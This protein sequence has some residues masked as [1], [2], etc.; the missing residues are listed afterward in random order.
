MFVFLT[1][2]GTKGTKNDWIEMEA[3]KEDEVGIGSDFLVSYL[4]ALRVLRS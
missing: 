2:K 4:R 3:R 1:T